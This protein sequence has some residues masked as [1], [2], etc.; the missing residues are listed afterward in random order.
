MLHF[1]LHSSIDPG[2]DTGGEKRRWRDEQRTHCGPLALL[3][4][5]SPCGSSNAHVVRAPPGVETGKTDYICVL[6]HI[7]RAVLDQRWRSIVKHLSAF[8]MNS[9]IQRSEGGRREA[10]NSTIALSFMVFLSP[11]AEFWHQTKGNIHTAA[12]LGYSS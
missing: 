4:P 6:F 3:I 1:S 11:A 5:P 7:G 8:V 2:P 12:Q 9:S 10:E